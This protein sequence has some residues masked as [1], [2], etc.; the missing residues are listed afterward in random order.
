MDKNGKGRCK[1]MVMVLFDMV[2]KLVEEVEK[3]KG[4]IPREE[5][6]EE[7]VT[8]I[9]EHSIAEYNSKG[10][11]LRDFSMIGVKD[12]KEVEVQVQK[13]VVFRVSS[14][15]KRWE[16]KTLRSLG[17]VEWEIEQSEVTDIVIVMID[18][19]IKD[20]NLVNEERIIWKHPVF[21]VE[22]E[23]DG[24][25]KQVM[26]YDR[27]QLE[28]AVIELVQEQAYKLSVFNILKQVY[29]HF[30][31]LGTL[32]STQNIRT[33]PTVLWGYTQDYDEEDY[34]F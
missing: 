19:I 27:I 10:L 23:E 9:L 33:A 18:G 24:E 13:Y 12:S 8:Y 5:V 3:L 25:D 28:E 17:E 6:I 34:K 1:V 15:Y 21:T 29:E 14:D 16:L 7:K 4:N 11:F 20:F 32:Y 2:Y 22:W 30:Q 26:I 31:V